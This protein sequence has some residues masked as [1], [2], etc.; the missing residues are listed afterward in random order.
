[1]NTSTKRLYKRLL[2]ISLTGLFFNTTHSIEASQNKSSDAQDENVQTRAP[3]TTNQLLVKV[4]S[5]ISNSNFRV[6]TAIGG[7]HTAI[8]PLL[9]A[10]QTLDEVVDELHVISTELDTEIDALTIAT[11]A[12]DDAIVNLDEEIDA[13]TIAV[14][15]V[16]TN[17]ELTAAILVGT[18]TTADNITI[19]EG[20]V[21]DAIT[22]SQS[23][24]Q[25]TGGATNTLTTIQG[26]DNTKN[27]T[28][29][30]AQIAVLGS[31][32]LATAASLATTDGKI[33]TVD[34]NVDLILEDTGTTLP[35]Q[36][37]VLG[38]SALATAANLAT[39]NGT[40]NTINTNV[41]ADSDEFGPSTGLY[42]SIEDS[43]GVV[44]TAITAA[45]DAD[46]TLGTAVVT[47]LPA[48]IAVLGNAALA[49]F[50]QAGDIQGV[51]FISGANDL[52]TITNSI[53]S[54]AT[55]TALATVD[56]NVD[57]I[58]EDTS[59]TL[60]AQIAV[61]GSS[62]LATAANLANL[63]TA[64]D[65]SGLYSSLTT[66]QQSLTLLVSQ[67][68]GDPIVASVNPAIINPILT[69]TVT[70]DDADTD[71]IAYLVT[72]NAAIATALTDATT[73]ATLAT[74]TY[75]NT[76]TAIS[77]LA[78]ALTAFNTLAVQWATDASGPNG[79]YG[80]S[81]AQ[82]QTALVELNTALGYLLTQQVT[83]P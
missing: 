76:A 26:T 49:T 83:A 1:M 52:V 42:L 16:P 62:A 60:P 58:L 55:S 21:T 71:A 24:I 35:A 57:L 47:T 56:A 5:S 67:L 72:Y 75:A 77:S 27:L 74:E 9:P 46:S 68:I 45:T 6:L 36:I 70:S 65:V 44:T 78:T 63:G 50:A 43:Q 13:L 48:Q 12:L 29:I 20:V 81:A 34:A 41:G 40:V 69:T 31:S 22:A 30:N 79:A 59:T 39:T 17:A 82:I 8:E 7:V 32:A 25:G 66:M 11:A 2:V 19:T 23:V 37:A 54:R 53:A 28:T 38:S 33:D 10:I 15:D 14:A 4:E 51:G 64:S 18:N 3:L 61:L 73:A 80:Y